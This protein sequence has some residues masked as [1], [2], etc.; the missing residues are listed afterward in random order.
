MIKTLGKRYGWEYSTKVGGSA[1]HV[2]F[3]LCGDG[4]RRAIYGT[5]RGN[6]PQAIW[7]LA[8]KCTHGH[9]PTARKWEG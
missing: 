3:I 4:C 5:A 2:G 7:N 1:H 9:A 6:V 8:R